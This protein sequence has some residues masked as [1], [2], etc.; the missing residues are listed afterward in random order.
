MQENFKRIFYPSPELI[1][2][3]EQS[4]QKS[5]KIKKQKTKIFKKIKKNKKSSKKNKNKN[6]IKKQTSKQTHKTTQK[7]KRPAKNKNPQ[8]IEY[9][10]ILLNIIYTEQGTK[11]NTF[12]ILVPKKKRSTEILFLYGTKPENSTK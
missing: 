1:K 6:R 12:F 2:Q 7:T 10:I 9:N 3:Y 4:P 5:H 11:Y 8:G